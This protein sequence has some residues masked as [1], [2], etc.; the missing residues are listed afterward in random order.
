MLSL[1]RSRPSQVVVAL[2]CTVVLLRM[3]APVFAEDAVSSLVKIEER[4]AITAVIAS[5]P[6]VALSD[7]AVA[8]PIETP[9]RSDAPNHSLIEH[10]ILRL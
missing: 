7:C 2:L 6:G 1:L 9:A 3:P 10:S 8:I 4:T 5:T